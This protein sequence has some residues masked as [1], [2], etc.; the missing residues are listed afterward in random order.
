MTS[1]RRLAHALA[2]ALAVSAA[3]VVLAA[4]GRP[5]HYT[6]TNIDYP[7]AAITFAFGLNDLGTQIV[8]NYFDVDFNRHAFLLSDGVFSTIDPPAGNVDNSANN[9][10]NKGQIVGQYDDSDG[11]YH[12]SLLAGGV[13]TTIDFPG[14]VDSFANGI[15]NSGQ[16]VGDY[17]DSDG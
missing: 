12:G 9:N 17:V 16:I 3:L 4:Q 7:G 1:S 6:Y 8:G 5:I 2:S 10:N 15:N 14:A 13:F 11:F